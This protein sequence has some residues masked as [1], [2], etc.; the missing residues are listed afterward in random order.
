MTAE[1]VTMV[2]GA[3]ISILLEVIP[4]LKDVW[5][6]WQWKPLTLLAVSIATPLAVWGLACHAGISF[7]FE[8]KCGMQGALSTVYL[9]F[10]AFLSSQ[11]TYLFGTRKL[12]N[13]KARL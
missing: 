12:P 8:V 5:S 3:I 9:G 1:F 13:V 7:P 6:E 10:L 2:T 4:G 11:T